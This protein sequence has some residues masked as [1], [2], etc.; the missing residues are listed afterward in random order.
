MNSKKDMTNSDSSNSNDS[1]SQESD[2]ST[3]F[4]S[5]LETFQYRMIS[6]STAFDMIDFAEEQLLTANGIRVYKWTKEN[7]YIVSEERDKNRINC[8]LKIPISEAGTFKN[9]QAYEQHLNYS[10]Y[11]LRRNLIVSLISEY[12]LLIDT[13]IRISFGLHPEILDSSK[14]QFTFSELL[15]FDDIVDARDCL[16]DKEIENVIRGGHS[17]QIN[18]IEKTFGI[19]ELS[20]IPGFKSFV[21]ITERRNVFVHCDG[22]VSRQYIDK[23]KES[24]VSLPNDCTLNSMLY[25]DKSYFI[26]SYKSILKFAVILTHKW[27]RQ[28]M[29]NEIEDADTHLNNLCLNLIGADEYDSAIELLEYAEAKFFNKSTKVVAKL[30]NNLNKAQAYKWKGNLSKM[31]QILDNLDLSGASD[32]FKLAELVLRDNS[33]EAAKLVRKIGAES[34]YVSEKAYK[35][36]PIF[37]EFRKSQEFLDAFEAVFGKKFDLETEEIV[38]TQPNFC[39]SE[40]DLSSDD[41]SE[42]EL[43]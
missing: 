25:V 16:I 4:Y 6:L 19:K 8:E 14:R 32:D 41:S 20:S 42:S 40:G 36:W 9:Y 29:R 26:E 31:N 3:S 1:P 43:N 22:K 12:D 18:Y 38:I 17:D 11:I 7:N 28:F 10:S 15:K 23:C 33:Q 39:D 30:L 34:E 37:K 2:E 5:I 21:E 13:L 24:K 27:W 35:I